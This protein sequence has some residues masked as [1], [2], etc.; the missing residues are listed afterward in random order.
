MTSK[1]EGSEGMKSE[2]TVT[3]VVVTNDEGLVIL[4]EMVVTSLP[5]VTLSLEVISSEV[6]TTGRRCITVTAEEEE[7]E[8]DDDEEEED[9]KRDF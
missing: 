4:P 3:G 2:V 8:E 1:E 9:K 6:V 7:E 5:E